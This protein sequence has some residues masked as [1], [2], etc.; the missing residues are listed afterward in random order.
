METLFVAMDA[1]FASTGARIGTVDTYVV[2]KDAHLVSMDGLS[3]SPCASLGS[4]DAHIGLMDTLI[5]AMDTRPAT[6]S[7]A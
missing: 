6:G 5:V 1:L 3:V 7:W 4:V 2:S